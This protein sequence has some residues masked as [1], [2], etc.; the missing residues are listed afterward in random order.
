MKFIYL[1]ISIV[2]I[3]FFLSSNILNCQTELSINLLPVKDLE[4][5]KFVQINQKVTGNFDIMVG[6]SIIKSDSD[7][8][9]I[10]IPD[11]QPNKEPD[12][13]KFSNVSEFKKDYS[14][15]IG[16]RYRVYEKDKYKFFITPLLIYNFF[17][18]F[19]GDY[20][21]QSKENINFYISDNEYIANM[22]RNHFYELEDEVKV[23]KRGGGFEF[24]LQSEF[25]K[26]FFLA[27]DS[28]FN[29]SLIN[30]IKSERQWHPARIPT[31]FWERREVD[32]RAR[33]FEFTPLAKIRVGYIWK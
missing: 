24:T 1:K 20:I 23:V 10:T 25:Y 6:F 8:S 7:Y 12:F 5:P 9:F 28:Q 27:I 13:R 21:D 3:T 2:L 15:S 16:L 31:K 29:Y 4:F 17:H 14:L 26:N 30:T 11:S 22:P 33:G 19:K 32:N 18:S